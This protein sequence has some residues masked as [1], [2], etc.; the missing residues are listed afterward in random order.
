[1][2]ATASPAANPSIEGALPD[3]SLLARRREAL[4]PTYR[5]FYDVPVQVARAEGVFLYAPDGTEYLD[6]YNN[7]PSVGH[8]H[9]AVA[10]AIA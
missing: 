3:E 10:E 7:V 8:C 2:S 9:P 1:M 6:V 5:L 4:G